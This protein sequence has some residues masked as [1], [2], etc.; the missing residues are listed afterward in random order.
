MKTAVYSLCMV[1][2]CSFALP[3]DAQINPHNSEWMQ[4]LETL[5]NEESADEEALA[6]LFDELSAI[7]EN[8]YNL[9]TVT[10]EALEKLPFLSDAQIENL[11]YYIYKYG[12]L[13]DIHELQN[14]EDLDLQTITYLLPFVYLGE[15]NSIIRNPPSHLKYSHQEV[16]L[17]TNFTV[18]EKAGYANHK[19]GGDPYYLGFRYGFSLSDK[20]QLGVSGEKDPGEPVWKGYNKVFDYLTGNLVF[21]NIG[22]LEALHFGNYRLSFGQGLVMNTNFSMGKTADVTNI[23]QKTAGIQRHLSTNE[24]QYF[25]GTAGTLQYRNVRLSL[26]YSNRLADANADTNTIY[27][28][29]TDGYHRTSN[30]LL[31]RRTAE[32]ELSGGN[33]QWHNPSLL[34]GL[35]AVA[36]HFNGKTLDPQWK[37]YNTFY[38]RGKAHA[39]VG[40]HYKYQLKKGSLQGETAIDRNGKTATV[41]HLMLKPASALHWAVSFRYYDP[42]YNALYGNGFSESTVVQNETGFYSGIQW[43]LP[44]SLELSAYWDYFRFPWLK[45]GIETPSSGNDALIQLNYSPRRNWQMNLRYKFKEKQKDI[46]P[47]EQHRWRYQLKYDA[48]RVWHFQS[49]VN[50]NRYASAVKTRQ[51][52]SIAQ[53]ASFAPQAALQIDG[54][55][56]CFNAEDWDTRISTY[57]KSI[58]YAFSFPTYYGK[59]LR[60]YAVLQWKIA[61]QLTVYVKGGSSHYFDGETIGSGLEAIQGKEKTDVYFL[62]KYRF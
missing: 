60:Y 52:W 30:E 61:K 17:R 16:L 50:Y 55:I 39:N 28:F 38:L 5:V 53:S 40:I 48:N 25:S 62:I 19:Y 3:I 54:G 49:Q 32:T 2:L 20:I 4:F 35:T 33:L 26:F 34:V 9:Q 47:Y 13:V 7:V 45:F 21:K 10:K 11:L 58:L 37:P 51:G 42:Q 56:A 22:I 57:E 59:G 14:V 31:K 1:G 43:Q 8:P 23:N 18:Q 46:L 44:H 6:D 12:P 29:Q 36:Y 41:H 24:S 27:S 15:A